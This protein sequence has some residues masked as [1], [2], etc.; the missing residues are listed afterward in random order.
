[1]I[2]NSI[3]LALMAGCGPDRP[4]TAPVSGRIT[5]GGQPVATGRII[6]YPEQGRSAIG[7]IGP[8]GVY[9]LTTFEPGDGAL[10]GEHQVTIQATK[11]TGPAMPSSFEEELRQGGSGRAA[12]VPAAVQWI[13][14]QEYSRRESSPLRAEVARGQNTVN[15]DLPSTP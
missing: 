3:A 13:V 8:E 15:F 5:L 9:T 11:V 7:A 10:L 4:E 12:S 14:P 2:A 6:F 1:M